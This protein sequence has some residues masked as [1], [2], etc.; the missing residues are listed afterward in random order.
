MNGLLTGGA[1]PRATSPW[2]V[3]TA[4]PEDTADHAGLD[5]V[6]EGC[7]RLRPFCVQDWSD[8]FRERGRFPGMTGVS[9]ISLRFFET[10][11]GIFRKGR[12]EGQLSIHLML[13]MKIQAG[14]GLEVLAGAATAGP[15][16]PAAAPRESRA[17]FSRLRHP[18]RCD[19]LGKSPQAVMWVLLHPK[20]APGVGL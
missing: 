20:E 11:G 5:P 3:G 15:L 12:Y 8:A 18:V 19:V 4:T 6:P 7:A 13:Q 1:Q 17:P 16:L 14:S 2:R 9:R 10:R